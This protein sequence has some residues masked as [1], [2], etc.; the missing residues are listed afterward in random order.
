MDF[1]GFCCELEMPKNRNDQFSN[2][3]RMF[4]GV[5]AAFIRLLLLQ[6][7]LGAQLFPI[8]D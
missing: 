2:P 1:L 5:A 6:P 7:F 3:L 4:C 8:K